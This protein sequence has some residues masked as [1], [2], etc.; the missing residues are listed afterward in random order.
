MDHPISKEL[1][2]RLDQSNVYG[3][4][5]AFSDQVTDAWTQAEKVEIPSDYSEIK[6]IVVAAMGGSSLGARVTLS[7]YADT[8]KVPLEIVNDYHLSGYVGKETLVITNSYSGTTE[9]V[10]AAY[11]EARERGA[12]IYCVAAGGTLSQ[13]AKKDGLPLYEIDPIYNPSNQ[14]RM[15]L[16]YSIGSMGQL[17]TKLKL[18]DLHD[19]EVKKSCAFVKNLTEEFKYDKI[20][21]IAV[22]I[23]TGIIG[24]IPILIASGHL[25]GAAHA[26]KNQ[27]NENAKNFAASF[28]IPELNHHLVEGL[29]YPVADPENLVFIFYESGLYHP[30]IQKRFKLTRELA[31]K[32]GIKTYTY[33]VR[34]G[35]KL[36]QAL[37]VVQFGAF[38]GFYLSMLNG[39]NPAP[40]P[41]V[42][43]F[44][45]QMEK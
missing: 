21:N 7:L 15:S 37:E 34:G 25:F 36:E 32:K 6:N 9:E 43:W 20:D 5:L 30:R 11:Q 40:I 4:V 31:E 39:V 10:I 28:P 41:I 17:L 8:L 13:M 2:E 33:K 26:A 16:G 35:N 3:S 1:I 24:K 19:E 14:P 45:E 38:V 22:D 27:I 29:T 44:K 23:S 18:I 12:K 42:D